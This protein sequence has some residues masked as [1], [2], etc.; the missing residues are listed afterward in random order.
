[1]ATYNKFTP[2]IENLFE[3]I[4]AGSDTWFIKL[5]TAVNQAAGTFTEVANGNGYTTGGNAATTST[6]TQTGG[7]YKLVLNSPAVWTGSGA[8]FTFQY[9]IL[10]DT[11][12]GT[13]VAYWDYGSSQA[14]AAGETVTVTLDPTNGV[15]QST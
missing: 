10:A 14:V 15:F 7:T 1:M 13:N 12:T 9:A 8:G 3:G 2:S 11:T 6:A 4:N 5:G